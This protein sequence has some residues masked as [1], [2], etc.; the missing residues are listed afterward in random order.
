MVWTHSNGDFTTV[1]HHTK[2]YEFWQKNCVFRLF[3]GLSILV[4][5][6]HGV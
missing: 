4:Y 5:T 3:L 6:D 1:R 2:F